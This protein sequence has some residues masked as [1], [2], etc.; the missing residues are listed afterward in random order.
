M[1]SCT[2]TPPYIMARGQLSVLSAQNLTLGDQVDESQVEE[3]DRAAN[4]LELHTAGSQFV[5]PPWTDCRD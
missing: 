5:S 3:P 1:W 2:C 4:P